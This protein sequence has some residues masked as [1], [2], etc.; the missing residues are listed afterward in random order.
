MRVE[1]PM[2]T[3]LAFLLVLARV[4]GAFVFVPL[5]GVRSGPELA[6]AGLS[7]AAT[8]VLFPVWPKLGD[9]TP[10]PGQMALWLAAETAFGVGAG[11]VTALLGEAFQMGAQMIGLQAGYSY[12]SMIDPN[13]AADARGLLVFPQ[14]GGS[15]LFFAFGM[16]R[17]V[18]RVFAR[19]LELL[20]PGTFR[21][22]LA[23][24]EPLVRLG[25]AML[26][27]GVRLALPVIALTVLVDITLALLSKINAH[28]QV[29][30]LA[31]PAKMLAAL[32][33]LAALTAV[34]PWL[35][36]RAAARALAALAQLGGC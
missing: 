33:T 23:T 2:G 12:A 32:A 14:L 29:L 21:P 22:T 28:L 24:A 20:P 19:S 10:A 7:V 27:T 8:L 30:T 11:A 26:A 17:E 15:L 35:Y 34:M 4:A 36:E 31:F 25:S 16:D 1:I 6:R 9:Q 3:L 5:P 18:I 13:R